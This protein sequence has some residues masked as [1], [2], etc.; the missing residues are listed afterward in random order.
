MGMGLAHRLR[1]RIRIDS[2]VETQDPQTGAIAE[3]WQPFAESVA[4]EIHPLSGGEVMRAAAANSTAR[5]RF[6]IRPIAGVT[7]KMSIYHDGARYNIL[8]VIPDPT[9]RHHITI[10]AETGLRDG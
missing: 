6:T 10:M 4:A 3:A 1:H 9:L 7:A 5:Y 2:L 8:D